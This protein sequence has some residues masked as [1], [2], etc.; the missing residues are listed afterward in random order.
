MGLAAPGPASYADLTVVAIGSMAITYTISRLVFR[1]QKDIVAARRLGS[2][3]LEEKI[4]SGG[5]GEV[6]AAAT[7]CWPARR[8]SS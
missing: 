2:Y 4:G 5:M 7:A 8:R 1:L 6:C 3:S